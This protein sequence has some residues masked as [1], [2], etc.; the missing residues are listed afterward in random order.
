MSQRWG[1]FYLNHRGDSDRTDTEISYNLSGKSYFGDGHS[2]ILDYETQNNNNRSDYIGLLRWRYRS[3][4]RLNGGLPLWEYDLGYGV[5][6]R[7]SGFYTSFSTG[8]IPGLTLRLR[9]QDFS[10]SSSNRQFIIDIFPRFNVQ[11]GVRTITS[12]RDFDNLRSQGD[13]GL[14]LFMIKMAMK[15]LMIVT[16]FSPRTQIYC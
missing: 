13:Y 6:S 10:I 12:E 2:L 16:K 14:N 1:S 9:Y 8:F 15:F 7:G 11:N 5:G 3:E 4:D